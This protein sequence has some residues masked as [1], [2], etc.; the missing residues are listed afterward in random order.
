VLKD[1]FY[2]VRLL[3]ASAMSAQDPDS[4]TY[5]GEIRRRLVELVQDPRSAIRSTA[6]NGLGRFHD[7]ALLP[8]FQRLL[9][10][11]SYY[12]EASAMNGIL[13]VD[14]AAYMRVLMPRLNESSYQ[15]ILA[16]AALGWVIDHRTPVPADS[17]AEILTIGH[18]NSL[19]FLAIR[20]MIELRYVEKLWKSLLAMLDEPDPES[21]LLA[22]SAIAVFPAEIRKPVLE[23]RMVIETDP[24][25]L[26]ALK[27]I[28]DN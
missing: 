28:I 18:S 3:A 12:V 13:A 26:E 16:K 8:V 20:A 5:A 9:D 2:G 21:R 24:E 6:C 15:D 19:R 17:I 10:D 1:P 22:V 11:S 4:C 14:S 25:V 7:R 27:K 23:A